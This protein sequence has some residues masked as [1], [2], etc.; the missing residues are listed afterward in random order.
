VTRAVLARMGHGGFC[1]NCKAC[2]F[3]HCPFGK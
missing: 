3:P 1:M 2:T